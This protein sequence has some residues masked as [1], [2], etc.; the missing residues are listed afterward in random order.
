METVLITGANRGIGLELVKCHINRGDEVI[1]VCRNSSDALDKSGSRIICG[2]DMSGPESISSLKSK[3]NGLSIDRVIANAGVRGYEDYDSLD[4]NSICYQYEVNALGP[5]RLVHS[6]DSFLAKGAKI[7]L[8]TTKVASL[9][10]NES[11]G[12]FGYR[13]SKV[14]LNMAGVNLAHALKPRKIAVFLLHPGYVRTDLTG[15]EGLI[16]VDESAASIVAVTDKMRLE[17]TGRFW[18]AHWDEEIPW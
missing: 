10:D 13:M 3:I 17:D 18:H 15:G 12:E 11:G 8:I 9:E 1:A 7:V 16:N 2:I 4:F 6:L 5:L 14:S